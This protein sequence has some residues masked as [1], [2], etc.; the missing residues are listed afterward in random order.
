MHAYISSHI[1]I[2][3]YLLIMYIF[4]V[5][6]CTYKFYILYIQTFLCAYI[7]IYIL[8]YMLTHIYV[9]YVYVVYYM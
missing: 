8:I 9:L 7:D 5:N 2:C 1:C 4:I 6:V 3:I